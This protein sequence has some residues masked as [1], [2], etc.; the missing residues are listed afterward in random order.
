MGFRCSQDKRKLQ[1]VRRQSREQQLEKGVVELEWKIKKFYEIMGRLEASGFVFDEGEV[2]GAEIKRIS[3]PLVVGLED[4]LS[5]MKEELVQAVE[6][7]EQAEE[8]VRKVKASLEEEKERTGRL[9]DRLLVV[10][11]ELRAALEKAGSECDS[12]TDPKVVSG[13]RAG[14]EVRREVE[15]TGSGVEW[16]RRESRPM[17]GPPRVSVVEYMDDVQFGWESV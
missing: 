16:R 2:S 10:E 9:I 7:R 6:G 1:G 12:G 15:V 11:E 8:T 3:D 4:A 13:E 5:G 14:D 17:G